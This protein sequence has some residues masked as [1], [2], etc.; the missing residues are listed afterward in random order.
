MKFL[1]SLSLLPLA[2]SVTP[3]PL[4]SYVGTT[5]S[6][7]GI[8][9]PI[10]WKDA[11]LITNNITS[12]D[13]EFYP[14]TDPLDLGIV[15]YVKHDDTRLYF[16][17][18]ISD[19]LLYYFETDHWLPSANPE[20]EQL[21][22]SGFPW[23]GDEMEILINA[24]NTYTS[25]ND[26]VTG[27]PGV[28]QMVCNAHK[29]RL[30]GMGKGGILEGEPRS[31]DTAWNNYQDWIYSRAIECAVH[32]FPQDSTGTNVY[33]MEWAIDFTP[34]LQ[35]APNTYYNNSQGIVEM[36]LNIAL[37]DVDSEAQA[38]KYGLRHEMWFSGNS[39]CNGN[40]NCHTLLSY[41]GSLIMH[42]G[43]KETGLE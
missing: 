43:G 10:E 28:F 25:T 9:D 13:A 27:V 42:P 1:S 30:G 8:L 36:G 6:L 24:P 3:S 39:S 2:L 7:D 16:G 31:S 14:V 20:A 22:R 21:T 12:F 40:G 17:F 35:T 33:G 26:G 37:G 11:T 34:L 15:G 5:P 23:F 4:H 18:N 19:N 38:T 29:S 41:F 32:I